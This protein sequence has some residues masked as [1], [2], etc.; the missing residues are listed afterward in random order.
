VSKIVSVTCSET[1]APGDIQITGDLTLTLAASKNTSGTS[2]L[3]T[4]TVK[5]S[6]ASGNSS[7]GTVTVTVP[8]SNGG[9]TSPSINGK[10]LPVM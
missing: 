7:F 8:K 2:R 9:S 4:I 1:P 10:R 6:D 3:Y 5:S